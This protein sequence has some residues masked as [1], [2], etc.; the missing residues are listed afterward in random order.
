MAKSIILMVTIYCMFF[1]VVSQSSHASD[2]S[3]FR[4]AEVYYPNKRIR[5][6]TPSSVSNNIKFSEKEESSNPST[7]Q[8]LPSEIIILIAD[9]LVGKD[10]Q[11]FALASKSINNILMNYKAFFIPEEESK[12]IEKLNNTP[13]TAIDLLA[14]TWLR[15]GKRKIF[16]QLTRIGKENS[17][18]V[19]ILGNIDHPLKNMMNQVELYIKSYRIMACLGSTSAKEELEMTKDINMCNLWTRVN[20]RDLGKSKKGARFSLIKAAMV[21]DKV[22][23]IIPEDYMSSLGIDFEKKLQNYKPFGIW[24]PY[25]ILL[26]DQLT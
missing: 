19:N 26:D 6:E 15:G 18:Y 24:I 12:V 20:E 21:S 11:N 7:I 2:T 3:G 22:E 25:K 10:F 8:Q 17:N 1:G 5:L 9:H 23:K 13:I 4:G 16:E 14:E